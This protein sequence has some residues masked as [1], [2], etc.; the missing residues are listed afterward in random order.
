MSDDD[1]SKRPAPDGFT[2]WPDYWTVQGMPWRTEP[3]IDSDRQAYLAMRRA[4]RPDIENGIYPFHDENGS[5]RLDRADVEWL[6]ATHES[7]GKGGPVWWEEQKDKPEDKR[8][9]GLDLRGADLRQAALGALPL[10]YM[11]GGLAPSELPMAFVERPDLELPQLYE[12]TGTGAAAIHLENADL[13]E[14]HLEHAQ[15]ALAHL[16]G[17]QLPAA[18]LENAVLSLAGIQRPAF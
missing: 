1:G 10:A 16:K 5:V 2:E 8:R 7:R 12:F 18:D 6:L 9:V 4:V 3:E 15:L 17:A 13:H 11:L 14:A